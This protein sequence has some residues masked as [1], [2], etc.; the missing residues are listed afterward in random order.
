MNRTRA[1]MGLLVLALMVSP[2]FGRDYYGPRATPEIDPGS[3]RS[4]L[5]L[6]AGGLLVLT[7]RRRRR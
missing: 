4:G 6:L 1:L 7:D 5:V 3:L 2:A